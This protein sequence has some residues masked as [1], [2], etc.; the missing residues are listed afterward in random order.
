MDGLE[1]TRAAIFPELLTGT[2]EYFP[3]RQIRVLLKGW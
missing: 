2:L 1:Q 3:F